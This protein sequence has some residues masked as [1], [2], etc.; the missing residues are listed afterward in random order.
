MPSTVAAQSPRM[1]AEVGQVRV[2]DRPLLL[3]QKI[4]LKRQS[5]WRIDGHAQQ[6]GIPHSS[7]PFRS[8]QDNLGQVAL[9]LLENS[10]KKSDRREGVQEAGDPLKTKSIFERVPPWKLQRAK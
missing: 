3:Q 2:E 6:L 8:H 5:E 9:D 7:S 1:K 10:G 4:R